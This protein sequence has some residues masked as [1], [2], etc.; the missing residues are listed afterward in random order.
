MSATPKHPIATDGTALIRC[1]AWLGV[2]IRQVVDA[3]L[4]VRKVIYGRGH[5]TNEQASIAQ[6]QHDPSSEMEKSWWNRLL[7]L[8]SRPEPEKAAPLQISDWCDTSPPASTSSIGLSPASGQL[9]SQS[10]VDEATPRLA[11][12]Q[13]A[14]HIGERVEFYLSRMSGYRAALAAVTSSTQSKL[15]LNDQLE[16]PYAM[17]PNARVEQRRPADE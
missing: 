15:M 9:P 12:K 6:P 17:T 1:T 10:D 11:Q 5:A 16:Q 8:K 7:H 2:I 4:Q 13:G 14:C 3:G